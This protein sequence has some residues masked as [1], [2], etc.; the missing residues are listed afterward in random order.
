MIRFILALLF[1]ALA[2]V[3]QFWLASFG[4]FLNIILAALITFAFLFDIW[5]LLFF[6]LT[7]V[8]VVNWQPAFS[9]EIALLVLIPIATYLVY[10][11][12]SPEPWA[13]S[14]ASIAIGLLVFYLLIAPQLFLSEWKL[15]LTDLVACI[16]FSSVTF[17][18]LNRRENR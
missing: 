11:R 7:A 2:F 4:V 6:I 10:R 15:F 16:V 17:S 13:A 5:D 1:L 9:L 14:I 8:L 12:M 3:L 18:A